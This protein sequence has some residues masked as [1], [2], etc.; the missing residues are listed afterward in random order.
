MKVKNL[1][2]ASL[3]IVAFVGISTQ[4][5]A[6]PMD[7]KGYMAH[8][9]HSG[10]G[11]RF[12]NVLHNIRQGHSSVTVLNPPRTYRA[13]PRLFGSRFFWKRNFLNTI[14]LLN[15]PIQSDIQP[16]TDLT[17]NSYESVIDLSMDENKDDSPNTIEESAGIPDY[18][19]EVLV[20]DEIELIEESKLEPVFDMGE[21]NLDEKTYSDEKLEKELTQLVEPATQA[22][23]PEPGTVLLLG[24]GLLGVFY[25]GKRKS[26][27]FGDTVLAS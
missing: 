8:F 15:N 25:A 22:S 14:E 26:E 20:S 6:I 10:S 7:W 17:G 2:A 12:S 13:K 23:V 3:A 21:I 1:L 11:V 19:A 9:K 27:K 16:T 5:F 24:L 18:V 4:S